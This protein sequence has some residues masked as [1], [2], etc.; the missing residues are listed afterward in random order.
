MIKK[1][2]SRVNNGVERKNILP[3]D[4]LKVRLNTIPS[5]VISKII[6]TASLSAP[7]N[8]EVIIVKVGGNN[9]TYDTHDIQV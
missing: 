5:Q 7:G 2:S 6:K 4:L 3:I 8:N 1:S 9:V